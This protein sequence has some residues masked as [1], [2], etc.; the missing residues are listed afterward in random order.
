MVQLFDLVQSVGMLLGTLTAPLDESHPVALRGF[1][2]QEVSTK[3]RQR[4]ELN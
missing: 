2:Y 3:V 1:I 4:G